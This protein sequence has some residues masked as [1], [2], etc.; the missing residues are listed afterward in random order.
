MGDSV[1]A[2]QCALPLVPAMVLFLE[3]ALRKFLKRNSLKS[4]E[5]SLILFAI[6]ESKKEAGVIRYT[7]S[8]ER[9]RMKW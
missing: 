4:S 3:S 2:M 5:G 1:V 8:Q 7:D 9:T 6:S